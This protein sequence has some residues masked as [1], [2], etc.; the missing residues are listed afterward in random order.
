[1]KNKEEL[2]KEFNDV[3]SNNTYEKTN[4]LPHRDNAGY[5]K[6]GNNWASVVSIDIRDFKRITLNNTNDKVVKLLQVFTKSLTETAKDQVNRS[7]FR[8]VYFAGDEVIVVF[9]ASTNSHVECAVDFATYANSLTN[10]LLSGVASKY[11]IQNFKCGIAVWTS[12]DNTLTMVGQKYSL[13]DS[14]TTLIGS[15]INNA[16][17]LGKKANKQ[18]RSPILINKQTFDKL[19]ES[20]KSYFKFV[21][22]E[23]GEQIYES[24]VTFK[25]YV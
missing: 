15:A 19:S 21:T 16:C 10:H 9:D 5:K 11:G 8:D 2:L 6:Y 7:A 25:N 1:M 12:N 23:F 24:G 13:E 22:Y 20:S 14:A 4:A 18:F 3:F 17:T